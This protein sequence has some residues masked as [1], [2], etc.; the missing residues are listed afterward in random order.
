MRYRG[1]IRKVDHLG[2]VCLPIEMRR[3][4]KIDVCD[5]VEI[6]NNGVSI[7]I[8]KAE[9]ACSCQCCGESNNLIQSNDKTICK[10]CLKQFNSVLR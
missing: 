1:I 6:I 5:E 3:L 7:V 9:G 10:D 8:V 4:L 2:R